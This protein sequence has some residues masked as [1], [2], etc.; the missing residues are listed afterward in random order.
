M[1]E[2]SQP[3]A[4]GGVVGRQVWSPAGTEDHSAE[5]FEGAEGAD[6]VDR[7]CEEVE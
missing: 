7:V 5:Q 3:A 1:S 4:R 6:K 2:C